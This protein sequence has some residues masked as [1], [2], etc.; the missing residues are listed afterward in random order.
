MIKSQRRPRKTKAQWQAIL[1]AFHQSNLSASTYCQ[2]QGLAYG[3][4]AKWRQRL[5]QV[6]VGHTEKA[7]DLIELMSPAPVVPPKPGDW[8]VELNWVTE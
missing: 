7:A 2:E 1:A 4:F 8:Q 5:A 3:T 6:R